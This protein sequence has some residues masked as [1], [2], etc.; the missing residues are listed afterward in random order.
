MTAKT[1]T[2]IAP[3]VVGAFI[4]VSASF[5][6]YS[7][8]AKAAKEPV[9]EN[10]PVTK[11]VS[12]TPADLALA[13]ELDR[14]IDE[15]ASGNARWGVFVTS[16]NDGRVIYSRNGDKLFTPASNMKIFTTAVA[17]DLLGPDYRWR[18][19]AY[20]E[21]QIDSSGTIA[22]DL[23][24]Y[25]RGAPDFDSK[26]KESLPALVDQ[27]YQRGL[28]H[29]RGNII[30]DQSYFRGS[31]YGDGWQW[32]D[33]QWYFGAEP[34]ALSIDE[35]TVEVTIAPA[36]KAGSSAD[37]VITPNDNYV[38]LTNS[39]KT[40]DGDTPTTI[41][42]IR[43][44]SSN[45]LRVWGEFPT[46]GRSF[47]AFLSIYDPARRAATLLKQALIARGIRVDGEPQDRDARVPEDKKF[48]P[49]KAI[50][51]AFV[52]SKSLGEIVRKTNKESNNL[53]AEL[54]LRTLGKER[55]TSAPDPDQRRNRARGDDVAGVAV[56]QSWL[57]SHGIP[58]KA[59]A[60]HDGSG[61]SRLD[62]ITPE[63]AAR[64]LA[65]MAK[66]AASNVFRDSLPIA[67][68]DGTLNGRLVSTSGRILA[69]TGTLTY[70]HSLSGYAL[71]SGGEV[72]SFSILCNDAAGESRPVGTIDALAKLLA[73]Y[74]PENK[75]KSPVK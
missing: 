52:E 58:A 71:T 34:S 66:S 73:A 39:T 47:S 45:D 18:T 53:Y 54:I 6:F 25:G 15:S 72:L 37:V 55:G 19:S 35:N 5:F 33:L 26:Q 75:D 41:G 63:S 9:A 7:R 20:T 24:L 46:R 50:E 1:R 67:G 4:L 43:D 13:G 30:G 51:M 11:P 27:L 3:L 69:K 48:D 49:Q 21:S 14:T 2:F 17:L 8:L 22:G 64:L 65:E 38:R 16:M 42:I 74:G 29:V 44:L 57:N 68:R 40:A 10:Q 62:L 28:R 32:N 70:D 61:L 59:L 56:I 12:N 23:I 60:L 36:G 31:L